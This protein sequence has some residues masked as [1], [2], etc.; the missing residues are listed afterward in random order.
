MSCSLE[1][2]RVSRMKVWKNGKWKDNVIFRETKSPNNNPK[3]SIQSSPHGF[4]MLLV[5]HSKLL[6]AVHLC[7][8]KVLCICIFW[9]SKCFVLSITCD[10]FGLKVF[11]HHVCSRF[12]TCMYR[13]SL[14]ES[15]FSAIQIT[16]NSE[17][18]LWNSINQK[19]KAW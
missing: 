14:M 9:I 11:V 17:N 5:H 12:P 16:P 7:W 4:E 13:V 2:T 8:L 18:M 15:F 1:M 6:C 10:C 19:F 3:Q